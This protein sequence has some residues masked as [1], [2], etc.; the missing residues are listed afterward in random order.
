MQTV[1]EVHK[2][3]VKNQTMFQGFAKNGMANI[4]LPTIMCKNLRETSGLVFKT[5]SATM[6]IIAT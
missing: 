6:K 3:N 2:D 5:I 4:I 1:Y